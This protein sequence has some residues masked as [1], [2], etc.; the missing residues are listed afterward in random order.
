MEMAHELDTNMN[1]AFNQ[2]CTWFAPKNKV[3]AGSY[4]LHNRIAFAVGINSIGL[5]QY[6]KRLFRK[7]GITMTDNVVHYLTIKEATRVKKH[8]GAK[9]STAKKEKNKRKYEKLKEHTKKAKLELHKRMGTYRK[10][11]NLDDPINMLLDG[12]QDDSVAGPEDGAKPAAKKRKKSTG[13]CEYCGQGD[14][15]SKRSKKCV[16]ALDSNKKY[17]KVDGSLLTGPPHVVDNGAL[18]AADEVND[19]DDCDNFDAMPLVAMPGEELSFDIESA[20]NPPAPFGED[21][22]DSDDDDIELVR[23]P[24]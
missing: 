11:M 24:I 4:S 10:G 18:L 20:L 2:I 9:T 22:G 12:N 15:L 21:G 1:E 5:L 7:L 6:F 14:H 3:F 23:A 17:R 13:F 19:F 8:E 16:A